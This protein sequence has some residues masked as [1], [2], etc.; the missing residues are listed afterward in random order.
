MHAVLLPWISH[1]AIAEWG[2][3]VSGIAKGRKIHALKRFLFTT[4]HNKQ[5]FSMS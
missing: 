2:R 1:L 4:Q 5:N 3:I